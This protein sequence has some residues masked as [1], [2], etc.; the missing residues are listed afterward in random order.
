MVDFKDQLFLGDHSFVDLDMPDFDAEQERYI[1]AI[2]RG[3]HPNSFKR[4]SELWYYANL[5]GS[6][7]E[8]VAKGHRLSSIL[9]ER[10][11]S[12]CGSDDSYMED[13]WTF[14]S[15]GASFILPCPK[16]GTDDH[17]TGSVG[18][19]SRENDVSA[20]GRSP[21]GRGGSGGA[22]TRPSRSK[23]STSRVSTGASTQSTGNLVHDV[24]AGVNIM[25]PKRLQRLSPIRA[26]TPLEEKT[27]LAEQDARE[28]I[29]FSLNGV[30]IDVRNHTP[31]NYGMRV[32]VMNEMNHVL[33]VDKWGHTRIK[34]KQQLLLSDKMCFK[35][36]DLRE[37][38]NP[39]EITYGQPLWLQLIETPVEGAASLSFFRSVVLSSKVFGLET[40]S[41]QQLDASWEKNAKREEILKREDPIDSD[42]EYDKRMEEE[43]QKKEEARM[44]AEAVAAS[45]KRSGK[46]RRGGWGTVRVSQKNITKMAMLKKKEEEKKRKKEEEEKKKKEAEENGEHEETTNI[47]TVTGSTTT[48][49]L[50]LNEHIYDEPEP[51]AVE[52][53][54]REALNLGCWQAETAENDLGLEDEY[55]KP[56]VPQYGDPLLSNKQIILTQDLYC[57]A[58]GSGSNYLPWP[59]TS[60]DYD[61][62]D[63]LS[64]R[65]KKLKDKE[66]RKAERELAGTSLT[67][68]GSK[69]GHDSERRR[70]IVGSPDVDPEFGVIRQIVR[71]RRGKDYLYCIDSKC[72]WRFGVIEA[73]EDSSK[74]TH[75]ELHRA[76]VMSKAKE[77]LRDSELHRKGKRTYHGSHTHPDEDGYIPPSVIKEKQAL[78]KVAEKRALAAL[79]VAREEEMTEEVKEV[80][81]A[82]D[83]EAADEGKGR[84]DAKGEGDGDQSQGESPPPYLESLMP[85]I[86]VHKT[87][88]L[89]VNARHR[90]EIP[91]G[92]KFSLM[93]RKNTTDHLR[94]R[95]IHLLESRRY[96]EAPQVSQNYFHGKLSDWDRKDEPFPDDVASMCSALSFD[97]VPSQGRLKHHFEEGHDFSQHAPME[98][99]KEE[100]KILLPVNHEN[101]YKD[102]QSKILKQKTLGLKR[103]HYQNYP[104]F[105][106][107]PST[108]EFDPRSPTL[109][110]D[111]N[112]VEDNRRM[113]G[114]RFAFNDHFL[115]PGEKIFSLRQAF[116]NLGR[117]EMDVRAANNGRDDSTIDPRYTTVVR[118]PITPASMKKEDDPDK[119]GE[120]LRRAKEEEDRNASIAAKVAVLKQE[121]SIIIQALQHHKREKVEAELKEMA[122]NWSE[123]MKRYDEQRGAA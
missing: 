95:E 24:M 122:A 11:S 112:P 65:V 22:L 60:N 38:H 120:M 63:P 103:A 19:L 12:F 45:S 54:S 47:G 15:G 81:T 16:M 58:D 44:L 76:K 73:L 78:K 51:G 37:Y 83:S 85:T 92:E 35:L 84:E 77:I 2:R 105:H 90:P 86:E 3:R 42:E 29:N 101:I 31:L 8:R 40:I 30:H 113:F 88:V 36:V 41:T 74:L 82:E 56:L 91:G 111:P 75:A 114:D 26:R 102:Q 107:D 23:N 110:R 117:G 14:D 96:Q 89:D 79:E 5:T 100:G 109:L 93:L 71:L 46:G 43:E 98:D 53:V 119:E 48:T 18:G 21:S 64:T 97:Y 49:H 68:K 39:G 80:F 121:D 57:L 106:K 50:A 4:N 27:N 70:G 7:V 115:S 9:R 61:M 72:M 69:I 34:S 94:K 28:L 118:T 59:L 10:E 123:E 62:K 87:P 32:V 17:S 55:G 108:K 66:K 13:D 104:N 116:D 99:K 52:I 1:R 20:N 25:S 33:C 67:K 6:R